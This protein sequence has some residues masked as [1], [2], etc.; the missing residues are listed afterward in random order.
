MRGTEIPVEARVLTIADIFD[1]LTASD[2]PY[3]SAVPV[4]L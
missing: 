3:K 2:R 4:G 1:S